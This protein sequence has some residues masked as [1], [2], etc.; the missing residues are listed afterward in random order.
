MEHPLIWF[1]KDSK[2][3]WIQMDALLK[4]YGLTF[5]GG[6]VP[7][8]PDAV[9][10]EVESHWKDLVKAGAKDLPMP[11]SPLTFT[12]LKEILDRKGLLTE[13]LEEDE[14]AG[15]AVTGSSVTNIVDVTNRSM[16]EVCTVPVCS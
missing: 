4:R 9:K 16:D 8:D 13:Q 12:Q 6:K 1:K 2:G 3:G 14:E 15:K 7:E 10:E 11:T 5:T